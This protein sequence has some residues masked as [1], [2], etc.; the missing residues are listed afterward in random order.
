MCLLSKT[1]VNLF[2][3]LL[4]FWLSLFNLIIFFSVI[5][6]LKVDLRETCCRETQYK[7]PHFFD[8]NILLKVETNFENIV[9]KSGNKFFLKRLASNGFK[10]YLLLQTLESSRFRKNILSSTII[11]HPTLDNFF[12]LEPYASLI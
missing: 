4:L 12:S 3:F 7:I 11:W 6:R 8:W 9:E 5:C 2:V 1:D 10:K